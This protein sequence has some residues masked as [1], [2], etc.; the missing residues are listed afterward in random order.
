MQT[1][2]AIEAEEKT[3]DINT[4]GPDTEVELNSEELS[5]E[6][7]STE[8]AE[9][10]STETVAA[11]PVVETKEEEQTTEK[12]APQETKKDELE[13]YSE[14]VQKRIAKL[15][16]RMRE[17]ERQKEEA[18]KFAKVQQEQ[19]EAFEKQFKE[20]SVSSMEARETSIKSGMEAAKAKLAAARE[21]GDLDAE[22]EAQQAVAQLAYAEAELK[23]Q[24]QNAE[25]APVSEEKPQQTL[26]QAIAPQRPDPKAEQWAEKNSWFGQ[27]EA[28]TYTAMGLHKKLTEEEGFDPRSDEYYDEIN[29]RIKLEFPHKF[30]KK[31]STESTARPVQQ[32]ASAT[33]S[34]KPGRKTVRLTPSQVAIA[35]KLGVPL[36][37]YAKQLKL[38]TKE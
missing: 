4:S 22:L 31:E 23:V 5:T 6:S 13:Q 21:A 30:D 11:E 36:E 17:A 3:V 25:K 15:T 37:D 9:N 24:K 32:V 14:S 2:K 33:R 18:I 10:T 28:M 1:E 8:Q 34:T 12:E 7:T 20:T 27:D 16:K 35:K 26:E 38:I 19:R 29:K